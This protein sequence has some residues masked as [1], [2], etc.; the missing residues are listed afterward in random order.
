LGIAKINDIET[1]YLKTTNGGATHI[2]II[3]SL[4]SH[5]QKL[6]AAKSRNINNIKELYTNIHFSRIEIIN[7]QISMLSLEKIKTFLAELHNMEIESKLNPTLSNIYIKK[8]LL[9]L[10][11]C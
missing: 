11:N 2:N 8:L 5:F 3:R 6:L 7:K 10:Y 9:S 4:L 1:L